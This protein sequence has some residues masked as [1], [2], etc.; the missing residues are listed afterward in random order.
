MTKH[1]SDYFGDGDNLILMDNQTGVVLYGHEVLRESIRRHKEMKSVL[2]KIPAEA[3]TALLITFFPEVPE[4]RHYLA[5]SERTDSINPDAGKSLEA[6]SN[7]I[8]I[9]EKM[10]KRMLDA[11]ENN[12]QP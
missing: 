7:A 9:E 12:P 8:L 1:K 11:I 6:V 3:Y 4:V 2:V 10:L 5:E